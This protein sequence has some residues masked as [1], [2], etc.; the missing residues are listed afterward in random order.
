MKSKII[1]ALVVAA[2]LVTGFFVGRFYAARQWN[3]FFMDYVYTDTSNHAHFY[4]RA[5]TQLRE[6]QQTNAVEF[7]EGR[8]DGELIT[9]ISLESLRPEDRSA[10]DSGRARLSRQASV[11]QHVRRNQ[12]GSSAGVRL[13]QISNRETMR[14]D[15]SLQATRDGVSS[16]ASRFTS[17]RPAC[18]ISGRYAA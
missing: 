3:R 6:G 5:L 14:P 1:T 8:L 4:V 12:R 16:S 2:A 11:A 17:F 7:L 15:K 18:L 10:R 13:D 9:Y